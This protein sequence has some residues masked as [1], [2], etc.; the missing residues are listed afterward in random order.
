MLPQ[1]TVLP[2]GGDCA[3]A[4]VPI[5]PPAPPRFSITTWVPSAS[6][7]AGAAMR[8]TMSTEPP[9]GK[10]TTMRS[11]RRSCAR[12]ATGAARAA[13]RST[14]RRISGHPHGGQALVPRIGRARRDHRLELLP[15][16]G[17]GGIVGDVRRLVRVLH[18]VVHLGGA[19]DRL[20]G[21]LVAR[22]AHGAEF[23]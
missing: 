3:T 15:S 6:P 2:S 8:L 22:G 7:I 20:D 11:G 10:G 23:E 17:I 14:R 5:M 21:Q 12:A 16:R 19:A 1:T 9:G 18:Q 13:A 4:C